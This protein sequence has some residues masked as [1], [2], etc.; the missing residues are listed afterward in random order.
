MSVKHQAPK[1]KKMKQMPGFEGDSDDTADIL[2]DIR[3]C[4]EVNA[5]NMSSTNENIR[6][7]GKAK[8]AAHDLGSNLV[9]KSGQASRPTSLTG[10]TVPLGNRRLS[11]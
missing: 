9:I 7:Q 1:H 11:H 8:L 10:P 2:K 5:E 4:L 3:K 6:A